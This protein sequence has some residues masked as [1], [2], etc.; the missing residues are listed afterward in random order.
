MAYRYV[1]LV[2]AA[3]AL[4]V[5]LSIGGYELYWS[6]EGHNANHRND[7]NTH[8]QNYQAGLISGERDKVT[9]IGQ[10]TTAIAGSHDASVKAADTTQLTQLTSA[11]CSTYVDLTE[12]PTDLQVA[13]K[14]LCK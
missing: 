3:I 4:L 14:Q 8:S 11:F 7:V 9:S 12:V 2:F 5:G 10:L 1:G 6:V 13:H